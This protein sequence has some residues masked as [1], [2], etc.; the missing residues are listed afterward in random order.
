LHTMPGPPMKGVTFILCRDFK[1]VQSRHLIQ[2]ATSL[3]EGNP[4]PDPSNESLGSHLNK[5]MN[6]RAFAETA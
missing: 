4:L 2:M 5:Y 1:R 6:L 3:T